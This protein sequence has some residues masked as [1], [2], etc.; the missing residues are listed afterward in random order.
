[1]ADKGRAPQQPGATSVGARSIFPVRLSRTAFSA[2][3]LGGLDDVNRISSADVPTPRSDNHKQTTFAAVRSR[4]TAAPGIH[5]PR[6]WGQW[7]GTRPS[8]RSVGAPIPRRCAAAARRLIRQLYGDG[9]MRSP[10][11]GH[12]AS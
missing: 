5:A 7:L 8:C 2:P 3:L 11:Y 4:P 10:T 9:R 12:A 1:M 6:T